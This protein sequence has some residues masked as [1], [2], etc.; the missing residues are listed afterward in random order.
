MGRKGRGARGGGRRGEGATVRPPRRPFSFSPTC[1]ELPHPAQ[2]RGGVWRG[3][4]AA[5]GMPA[6]RGGRVCSGG[7]EAPRLS[8]ARRCPLWDGG[9]AADVRH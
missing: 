2:R 7:W 3:L 9:T 1:K 5:K 6:D 4:T 8:L